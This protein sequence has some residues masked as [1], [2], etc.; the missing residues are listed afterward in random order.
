MEALDI[1]DHSANAISD[2][3]DVRLSNSS[4]LNLGGGASKAKNNNFLS[5]NQEG[6]SDKKKYTRKARPKA[7]FK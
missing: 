4:N 7:Q 6:Q 5:P 1:D 3:I 2:E